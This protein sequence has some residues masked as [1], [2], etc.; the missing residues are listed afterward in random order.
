MTINERGLE[1]L[2]EFEGCELC[3]YPDIEGN[4][5]I[6]YGH[7]IKKGEHF[8]IISPEEAEELLVKDLQATVKGITPLLKVKVNENQFSALVCF[9]FNL[10]IDALANSTL[11]KKL[12]RGDYDGAQAEF[13]RWNKARIKGKLRAVAGLTRRRSAEAALFGTKVIDTV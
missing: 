13:L 11:L 2:K 3:P 12:N 8:N 5:T 6:G 10:G 4:P 1:L 7:L 9:A